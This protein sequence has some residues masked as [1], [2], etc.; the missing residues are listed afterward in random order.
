MFQRVITG[1][2][3][4]AVFVPL[5]IFSDTPIFT[6]AVTLLSLVG[7]YEMLKCLK[8]NKNTAVTLPSLI[9]AAGSPLCTRYLGDLS[10]FAPWALGIILLYLFWLLAYCVI[11]RDKVEY[12]SLSGAF[13]SVIYISAGFSSLILL[14]DTDGGAY[15]FWLVFIGAWV[16][17]TMAYF[18]GFLFGRHKLIPEVSPKKTVE[19]AIGGTLFSGFAFMLYGFVVSR[20]TGVDM[21]LYM[22]FIAGIISAVVAQFGDLAASIIKRQAGIKDYGNIFPGHGGVLDRFDSIIALSPVILMMHAAP[23]INL[24]I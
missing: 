12:S 13:M 23:F 10:Y 6:V 16:T 20:I 17:D 8:L 22:L 5:L 7:T 4:V 11:M 24:I 19:G 2:I 3:L 15:V 21:H 9:I 14:R 1:I 18:T